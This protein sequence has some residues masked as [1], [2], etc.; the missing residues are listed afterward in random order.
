MGS[1]SHAS[2]SS[3]DKS[4]KN[5]TISLKDR[6]SGF[7]PKY[8]PHNNYNSN[9]YGKDR[10]YERSLNYKSDRKFVQKDNIERSSKFVRK[11]ERQSDDSENSSDSNNAKD[12]LKNRLSSFVSTS[13]IA[14][15]KL[16]KI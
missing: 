2:S 8:T 3:F 5:E 6:L 15:K 10:Y 1:A 12:D 7:R 16:S 4:R 9:L 13:T 11:E 14:K